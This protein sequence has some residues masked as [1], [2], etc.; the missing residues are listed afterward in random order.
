MWN[1][2][3]FVLARVVLSTASTTPCDTSIRQV[4]RAIPL[5]TGGTA[6]KVPSTATPYRLQNY[7]IWFHHI[8][9]EEKAAQNEKS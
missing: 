9:E 2:D 8:R 6:S 5:A 1:P 3:G 4:D 7:C